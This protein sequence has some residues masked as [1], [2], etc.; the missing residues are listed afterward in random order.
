MEIGDKEMGDERVRSGTVLT[1]HAIPTN[2]TFTSE[3]MA[4]LYKDQVFRFH[5]IPRKIIHD[6]G[7][8]FQSKFMT[9]F[10]ASLGIENN[11]STAFHPPTDGRTERVNQELEQYFRV[12]LDHHR[13]DWTEWIPMAEFS[14]NN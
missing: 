12:F 2:M 11:P 4:K 6:R 3:G 8:Q 7:P 10:C 1:I 9:A 5:G 14:Y 13:D